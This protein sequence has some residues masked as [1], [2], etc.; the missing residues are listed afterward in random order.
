MTIREGGKALHMC[1]AH[2]L[3]FTKSDTFSACVLVYECL[4]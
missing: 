3:I 4:L 2:L 1:R